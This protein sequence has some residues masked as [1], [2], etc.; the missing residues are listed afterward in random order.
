M[1]MARRR[2][3]Q[4]NPVNK[5]SAGIRTCLQLGADMTGE[6]GVGLSEEEVQAKLVELWKIHREEVMKFHIAKFPG[7]RPAT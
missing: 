4:R 7:T 2:K 5:L 1:K 3:T 6:L